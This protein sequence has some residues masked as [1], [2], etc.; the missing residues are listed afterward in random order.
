MMPLKTLPCTEK[1]S[2]SC[3]RLPNRCKGFGANEH[4]ALL[5]SC[6]NPRHACSSLQ[7]PPMPSRRDISLAII[8][9][10]LCVLKLG[11]R[12]TLLLFLRRW[13][14][15]YRHFCTRVTQCE[16]WLSERTPRGTHDKRC[17][18][19]CDASTI[20]NGCRVMPYCMGVLQRGEQLQLGCANLTPGLCK[21]TYVC[22]TVL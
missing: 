4:R 18:V 20:L 15:C 5:I 2:C 6:R 22:V 19:I 8:W 13:L 9:V 21:I 1:A 11:S 14:H 3:P 12:M 10:T 7:L 17:D 16:V